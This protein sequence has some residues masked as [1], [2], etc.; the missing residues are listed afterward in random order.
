MK[1][2][3]VS[4]ELELYVLQTEALSTDGVSVN[5]GDD[6]GQGTGQEEMDGWN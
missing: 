4:P 3:Y 5:I 6:F 1:K 2:K